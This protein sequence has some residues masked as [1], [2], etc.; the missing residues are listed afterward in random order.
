MNLSQL[1]A[2]L[3]YVRNHCGETTEVIVPVTLWQ[4]LLNRLNLTSSG[5]YAVDENEPK[6]TVLNDLQ[7][8][9]KAAEAGEHYPIS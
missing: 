6:E 4:M 8:S 3:K 9:L 2:H 7:A 5:L 1:E